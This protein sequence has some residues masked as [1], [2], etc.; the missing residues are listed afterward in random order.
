MIWPHSITTQWPPTRQQRDLTATT[1]ER[2]EP[3]S[4]NRDAEPAGTN[5]HGVSTQG[6]RQGNRV[7]ERRRD[8]GAGDHL[9]RQ[10]AGSLVAGP[11]PAA[12]LLPRLGGTAGLRPAAAAAG[13]EA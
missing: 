1:W 5:R 11:G 12:I 9:H 3:G 7:G 10:L 13:A 2:Y 8:A 4:D 6:N